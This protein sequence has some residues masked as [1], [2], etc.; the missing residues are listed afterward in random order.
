MKYVFLEETTSS[1]Q[2]HFRD[3]KVFACELA[4]FSI[5]VALYIFPLNEFLE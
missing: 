2:R 4:L 5:S 3:L 1:V